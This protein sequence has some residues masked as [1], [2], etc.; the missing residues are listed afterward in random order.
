M[1]GQR[2]PSELHDFETLARDDSYRDGS[3]K[4]GDSDGG[5]LDSWP[6]LPAVSVPPGMRSRDIAPVSE[7]SLKL[8]GFATFK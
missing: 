1:R 8:I 7:I 2:K 5:S 6:V 3:R 4:D